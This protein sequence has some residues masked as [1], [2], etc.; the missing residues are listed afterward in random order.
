MN[1]VLISILLILPFIIACEEEVIPDPPN[2]T[3]STQVDL[4][5]L[6]VGQKSTYLFYNIP[7]DPNNGAGQLS[8]T[9]DTAWLSINNQLMDRFEMKVTYSKDAEV[10]TYFFSSVNDSIRIERDPN[11][12][13][14]HRLL[15]FSMLPIRLSM[16][17]FNGPQL[18]ASFE[19][20]AQNCST[21]TCNA[22]LSNHEQLGESYDR[23]NIYADYSDMAFDGPGYH[24]FYSEMYG[25]VRM[26][27]INA[28][29]REEA[30]WDFLPTG[31]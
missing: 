16:K 12:S 17:D 11:S 30:G 14:P 8:Y 24:M 21:P 25:M 28:W 1:K 31:D 6:V 9:G 26:A 2:E 4:G 18:N 27:S 15:P 7:Y 3:Q 5:E 10:D 23:L 19:S 29:T 20:I 13:G 22:Y